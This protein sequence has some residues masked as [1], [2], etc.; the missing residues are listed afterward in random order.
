MRKRRHH[1]CRDADDGGSAAEFAELLEGRGEDV[2]CG[3]WVEDAYHG[4]FHG[5]VQPMVI[6]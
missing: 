2:P 1:R 4:L 6:A 3:I 5:S